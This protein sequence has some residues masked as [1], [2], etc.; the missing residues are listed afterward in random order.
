MNLLDNVNIWIFQSNPKRYKI[1]EALSD[2]KYQKTTWQTNRYKKDIKKGDFVLLWVAGK[3]A[4]IYATARI[5]E[6]PVERLPCPPGLKYWVDSE[7]E[8]LKN[9]A[10]RA[11]LE[12]DRYY[13]HNPI[14]RE[15]LK[16]MGV[17]GSPICAPYQGTV[18]KV[19]P[20]DWD[21]IKRLL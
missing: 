3:K 20:K 1:I 21:I 14:T 10:F 8:A 11:K 16:A 2:P 18:F 17:K 19:K 13:L 9:P 12:I 6:N 15:T 4:G 7:D 5:I